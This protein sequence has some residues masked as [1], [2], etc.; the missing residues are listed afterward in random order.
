MYPQTKSVC[1]RYLLAAVGLHVLA[2]VLVAPPRAQEGPTS[3]KISRL[4]SDVSLTWDPANG[5]YAVYRSTSPASV[6]VPGNVIEQTTNTSFLDPLSSLPGNIYFYSVGLYSVGEPLGCRADP[7]CDDNNQCTDD[8]CIDPVG[9]V[10]AN[11]A[12]GSPCGSVFHSCMNGRC[13]ATYYVSP[14]GNDANSGLL[15][16]AP[17]ATVGKV[18][19]FP[20]SPGDQ[21]L[22]Q[23]G[24][25]W[26]ESLVPSVS[27]AADAPITFGAYGDPELP[28]PKFWGS[29]IVPNG[30]FKKVQSR[31]GVYRAPVFVEVGTLFENH[32]FLHNSA[33]KTGQIGS[34]NT[35][36]TSNL[37]YVYANRGSYYWNPSDFFLYVNLGSSNPIANGKLYTVS[38]LTRSGTAGGAIWVH[39]QSNLVFQDLAGD[40]T[41]YWNGGYVFRSDFTNNVKWIGCDASRGGKHHFGVINST[42]FVGEDLAASLGMP[43]LWYGAATAFVSYSST[44]NGRQGDTS[45]WRRC[46]AQNYSSGEVSGFYGAFYT[47][48]DGLGQITLENFNSIAEGGWISLPTEGRD[49]TIVWR[50]GVIDNTSIDI[51]KN[52]LI[53]GVLLTGSKAELRL[54]D[55]NSTAQNIVVSGSALDGGIVSNGADNIIRFNT[56]VMDSTAPSAIRLASNATNNQIYANLTAGLAPAIKLDT[57]QAFYANWN[58]YE[59]TP[60]FKMFDGSTLMLA[61]WRAA[62]HDLQGLAAPD[63]RFVDR[64]AGNFALLPDS[65]AI[66][67]VFLDPAAV[68]LTEDNAGNPRPSGVAFDTGAYET[69]P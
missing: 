4:A 62:G 47:H 67:Q 55:T 46:T 66:D 41:A 35:N 10:H 50:G 27:G 65:P 63:A 29:D 59:G 43:D 60:L 20:F 64:G 16:S 31:Q 22:F 25:E 40:E 17:W 8:Q 13:V 26:R 1:A 9:C 28:K 18:N 56:I 54:N 3:L 6:A 34:P 21:V 32:Q 14:V 49:E 23:R 39:H 37:N 11:T 45:I 33:I 42:G 57:A 7:N 30:S 36:S 51:Y 38:N 5:I 12:A 24:G 68:G 2:L 19:A 61:S 15:P 48:G 58:F 44:I 69:V 52:T 53:D